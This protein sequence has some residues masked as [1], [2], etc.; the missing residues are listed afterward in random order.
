MGLSKI[1]F[2]V[3]GTFSTRYDLICNL[4]RPNA[5]LECTGGQEQ[6]LFNLCPADCNTGIAC[7]GL[8]LGT[9]YNLRCEEIALKASPVC[10]GK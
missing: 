3:P 6:E 5:M 8:T 10:F 4:A 7:A 2:D 1:Y 9:E